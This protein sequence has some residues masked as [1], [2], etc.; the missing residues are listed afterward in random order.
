MSKKKNKAN[1][2]K[3]SFA[4]GYDAVASVGKRKAASPIL[5]NEDE[6]FTASNVRR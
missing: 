4:S 3:T 2:V 5:K 1:K 6:S